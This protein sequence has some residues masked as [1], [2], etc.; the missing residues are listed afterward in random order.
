MWSRAARACAALVLAAILSACAT[1]PVDRRG[2]TQMQ[3]DAGGRPLQA[4]LRT[5]AGGGEVLVV[6]LEGDGRAHDVRGRP[7]RDPTPDHSVGRDI[8]LAWPGDGVAWLA[9]PCQYVRRLDKACAPPAWSRDRFGAAQID[10][11]AAGLD[12][13][14][15]RT[16]ARRLVLVG[17]SGGGVIA[18]VLATRRTDVEALVTLAAP[19]DLSAWAT[20]TQTTPL[21]APPIA[22]RPEV[23]QL[24]LLGSRD[25]VAPPAALA[26][27]ARMLA[28][29]RGAVEVW[30]AGHACCWAA[31]AQ[32]VA[33]RLHD[34]Q[35]RLAGR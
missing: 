31:E 10:T 26:P 19:L 22:P 9:R 28:G 11:M 13:L 23:V 27:G 5:A 29:D 35:T 2:W 25:R 3:I 1:A 17:W 4:G 20:A 33:G 16:K 30:D 34:L 12:A 7:T 14:K 32:H 24:H 15:A 8:A 21:A 18:A 6:V